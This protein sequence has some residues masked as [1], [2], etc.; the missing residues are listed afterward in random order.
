MIRAVFT[1]IDGTL[2]NSKRE[3]TEHTKDVLRKCKEEKL[4]IILVSGRSREHMLKF[5]EDLNLS[6]YL[7]SSNGAD[8]YNAKDN[9]TIYSSCINKIELKILYN[10]I[11]QNGYRIKLNY[12]DKM[13][14]NKAFH[15]DEL[16][17]IKKD[18]K[19]LDIIDKKEIVQCVVMN[20]DLNKMKEFKQY[21]YAHFKDLKIENESKKL[22]DESLP[23]ME[24][25]YCDI[26]NKDVSKGQAVEKLARK[27]YGS[28][29][30]IVTVGDGEND[31]SMFK[32]TYNSVAMGNASQ[33][34][35]GFANYQTRSNDDEGLAY[36]L[37][38][39]LE[40]NKSTL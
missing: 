29:T 5:K 33:Y 39:I 23:E 3:V 8:I 27:L 2:K 34:V 36:M 9:E 13:L 6:D 16:L 32:T 12:E 24:Q 4:E 40:K 20:S 10:Y 18:E 17:C 1:D 35:K 21:F 19:I 22:I 30:E 25:Y 38:T 7:I 14:V 11:K 31:I 37:E 26:I 15:P 28:T